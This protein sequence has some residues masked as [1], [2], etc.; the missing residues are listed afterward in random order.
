MYPFLTRALRGCGTADVTV[1]AERLT[2]GARGH[3]K[4]LPVSP[5][6]QG[7]GLR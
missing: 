4:P 1:E 5:R 7:S 6:A 2:G 3:L